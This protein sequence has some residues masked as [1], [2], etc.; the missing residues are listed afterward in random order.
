MRNGFLR[1]LLGLPERP[2]GPQTVD[3]KMQIFVKITKTITIE[4]E[5]ED[6]ILKIKKKI[7]EKEGI[8]QD[9]QRL[10]FGGKQLENN[11]TAEECKIQKES[12]L[13]LIIRHHSPTI[14]DV[15][16]KCSISARTLAGENVIL[17][18]ETSDKVQTIINKI[19]QREG[20]P[21]DHLD[22]YFCGKR[23][24]KDHTLKKCNI[25]LDSTL[26]FVVRPNLVTLK[27]AETA[28]IQIFVKISDR[29][30]VLIDVDSSGTIQL[31][32]SKIQDIEGIPRKDQ[33]LIFDGVQLKDSHTLAEQ[34]VQS[35]STLDLVVR[36]QSAQMPS[37]PALQI[38]LE[39]STL[40]MVPLLCVPSDSVLFVKNR[41]Q[42]K[43]GLPSDRQRLILNGKVLHDDKTLAEC[44]LQKE[45]TFRLVVKPEKQSKVKRHLAEHV[46]V[47][48]LSGKTFAIQVASSETILQLKSKTQRLVGI[49]PDFQILMFAGNELEDSKSIAECKI[50]MRNTLYLVVRL[51]STAKE[52][53]QHLSPSSTNTPGKSRSVEAVSVWEFQD[54]SGR[55]KAM[56]TQISFAIEKKLTNDQG[57]LGKDSILVHAPYLF[58]LH[59]MIQTNIISQKDRKIRRGQTFLDCS[60]HEMEESLR[61]Q[62]PSDGNS[63]CLGAAVRELRRR[64]KQEQDVSA[65]VQA[66]LDRLRKRELTLVDS[67]KTLSQQICELSTQLSDEKTKVKD[68]LSL[69]KDE[70][71]AHLASQAAVQGANDQLKQQKQQQDCLHFQIVLHQFLH[72]LPNPKDCGLFRL[73]CSAAANDS[74]L[75]SFGKCVENEFFRSRAA[76]R[77]NQQSSEICELPQYEVIAI[78]A[79]INPD[80]AARQR[81]FKQEAE[82]RE[83]S[84][85][86]CYTA[87]KVVAP[88]PESLKLQCLCAGQEGIDERMLLGWHG[89]CD[90]AVAQII[91][92]GFNP[93]C[94]GKGAG[95][96]FGRGLYFAENS[97]KAD[98]YSGPRGNR[99]KKNAGSMCLI[100]AAVYCGNMYE[101][102]IATTETR[103]WTSAPSPTA[104]Q[105]KKS[106]IKR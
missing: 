26:Y 23:L 83:P 93:C 81:F 20:I 37:H 28:T 92:D 15:Q 11:C 44:N 46:F 9:L 64:L 30:T 21:G 67:V 12:T 3:L 24:D 22:L 40:G 58:D 4:V 72:A 31:V 63:D 96:L 6:T 41:I 103:E 104:A 10:I 39:T 19:Q 73:S 54:D 61:R 62:T 101:G 56:H 60:L 70:R 85:S 48:T 2:G 17:E 77:R 84:G 66:E 71:A 33:D 49:P 25:P 79:V 78:E 13:H 38:L 36:S 97:S 82:A 14:L 88:A 51:R 5:L 7:E 87:H 50:T 59:S 89:A 55:W 75:H 86:H 16:K 68:T 57:S 1:H 27:T 90:E 53:T 95:S 91:A 69:L 47:K 45:S 102:K 99:F 42:E 35:H 98:H 43:M 80:L 105:F 18:V 100:L 76:H 29:K 8:P 94:T 65:S 106:G 34:N 74:W 52:S 32:K